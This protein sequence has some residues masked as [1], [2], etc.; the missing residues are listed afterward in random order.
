MRSLWLLPLLLFGCSTADTSGNSTET[1]KTYNVNIENTGTLY[2]LM[3]LELEQVATSTVD[4]TTD[5]DPATDVSTPI[6]LAAQGATATTAGQKAAQEVVKPSSDYTSWIDYRKWLSD[7]DNSTKP[8]VTPVVPVIEEDNKVKPADPETPAEPTDPFVMETGEYRGRTDDDRPTW[9]F[10]KDLKDYPN[11]FILSIPECYEGVVKNNG[12]RWETDDKEYVVKQSDKGGWNTALFGSVSCKSE[13]ASFL[14][15]KTDKP[16]TYSASETYDMQTL[17]GNNKTQT[18]LNK[19]GSYYG[20]PIKFVFS[21]GCGELHV[22]DAKVTHGKD[23][24]PSNHNQA[25]YFCGSDF[26]VG[27]PERSGERASVF[28]P[29]GCKAKE[30]TIHYNPSS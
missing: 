13:S 5:N 14:K 17:E 6:S 22:P 27:A 30:V 21:D 9:N 29:P 20:G 2:M 24:N 25:F 12:E 11:A 15:V 19:T 8:V 4:Q 7:N 28:G 18:W 23:G 16:N 26:P 10:A 3:P 1:E